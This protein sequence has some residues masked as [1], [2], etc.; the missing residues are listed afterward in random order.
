MGKM[1]AKRFLPILKA[2][3]SRKTRTY[4]V[5]FERPN[6]T[7]AERITENAMFFIFGTNRIVFNHSD[8]SKDG[9]S[10]LVTFSPFIEEL[11][12]FLL[13]KTENAFGCE[14]G[15]NNWFSAIPK[16]CAFDEEGV[17]FS[18]FLQESEDEIRVRP[19]DVV[20][21]EIM[22]GV[23]EKIHMTFPNKSTLSGK[24]SSSSDD[25]R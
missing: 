8:I 12:L 19:S 22:E 7:K 5:L 11:N 18:V 1:E 6:S 16:K 10:D 14:V 25:I 15:D 13:E 9:R 21:F 2:S 3:Y 23:Y 20:A 17:Y 4:S 24:D